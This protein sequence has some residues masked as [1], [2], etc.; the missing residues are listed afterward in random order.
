MDFFSGCIFA[1][2]HIQSNIKFIKISLKDR[3]T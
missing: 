2:L 3:H 1:I